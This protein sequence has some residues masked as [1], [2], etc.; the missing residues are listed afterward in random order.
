MSVT[1]TATTR[2][3]CND[4]KVSVHSPEPVNGCSLPST[5]VIE[6]DGV[7]VMTLYDYNITTLIEN[8]IVAQTVMGMKAGKE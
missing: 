4:V 8:L 7:E 1:Y 3:G 6:K 2:I 5:C